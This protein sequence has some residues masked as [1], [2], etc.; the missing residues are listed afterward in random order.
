M[1][2]I[3]KLTTAV[4]LLFAGGAAV[5][6]AVITTYFKALVPANHVGPLLNGAELRGSYTYEST[7][8]DSIPGNQTFA[9][10]VNAVQGMQVYFP[11]LFTTAKVAS[12]DIAIFNNSLI[13]NIGPYLDSY[14]LGGAVTGLS[15]AGTAPLVLQNLANIFGGPHTLID[16]GISLRQ[17][18]AGTPPTVLLT[19]ALPA[20]PPNFLDFAEHDLYL[21]LQDMSGQASWHLPL[22]YLSNVPIEVPEPGSAV[23]LMTAVIMGLAWRLVRRARAPSMSR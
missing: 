14:G 5:D 1:K 11:Y 19:D 15:G 4:V 6:A 10:Y 12:G 23:L 18:R 3:L 9:Q 7:T 16:L 13:N 20:N 8:P 22:T 17:T 2:P 21:T